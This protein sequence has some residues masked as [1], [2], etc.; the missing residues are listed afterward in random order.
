MAERSVRHGL[1]CPPQGE[2]G[3]LPRKSVCH[4]PEG[5]FKMRRLR[6]TGE[7]PSLLSKT[8]VSDRVSTKSVNE[9]ALPVYEGFPSKGGQGQK[10]TAFRETLTTFP[11]C[12]SE[13]SLLG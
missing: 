9:T 6:S 3:E 11:T 10:D 8:P 5:S 2:K 7:V 12:A 4:V 13:G 1:P